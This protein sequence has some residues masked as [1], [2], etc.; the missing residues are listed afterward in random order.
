MILGAPG[1]VVY[2]VALAHAEEWVEGGVMKLPRDMES[3]TS[4][5][6]NMAPPSC[7][8]DRYLSQRPQTCH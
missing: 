3:E 5:A 1:L 8:G 4:S 7:A 2:A 6:Q